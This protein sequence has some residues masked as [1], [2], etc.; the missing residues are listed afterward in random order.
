[1]KLALT[2]LSG[3][4]QTVALDVVEPPVIRARDPAFF[5]ASI[6]KRSAAVRAAIIEQSDTT[7]FISEQHESFTKNSHDLRGF[8]ARKLARDSHRLPV[9]AKQVPCGGSW[10]HSSQ[11]FVLFPGEHQ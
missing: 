10:S 5:H 11:C 2:R 3:R 7:R 9:T 6:A 1:M 4:F 8:F